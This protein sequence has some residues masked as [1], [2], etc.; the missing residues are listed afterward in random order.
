MDKKIQEIRSALAEI[1]DNVDFLIDFWTEGEVAGE[2][3]PNPVKNDILS[4]LKWVKALKTVIEIK[5]KALKWYAAIENYEIGNF[6]V[7]QNGE[8][9]EWE[10]RVQQDAGEKAR[11]ALK[12][13][14]T[15]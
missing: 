1:P 15:Q 11:T 10:S 6:T 14:D 8:L 2:P 4:Y 9:D 5:D 13:E 3:L 12:G 7:D